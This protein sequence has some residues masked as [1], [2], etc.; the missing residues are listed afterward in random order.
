MADSVSDIIY[1]IFSKFI[2]AAIPGTEVR[3]INNNFV[4]PSGP[5]VAVHM[6]QADPISSYQGWV[7]VPTDDTG[8]GILSTTYRGQVLIRA[9][10]EHAFSRVLSIA[11]HLRDNS[12]RYSLLQQQGIGYTGHTSPTDDSARVDNQT[13]EERGTLLVQFNFTLENTEASEDDIGVIETVTFDPTY[14]S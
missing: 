4:P 12:L 13:M 7:S 3:Q 10:G 9:F 2:K 6:N 8:K 11:H 5:Y 1:R 14:N